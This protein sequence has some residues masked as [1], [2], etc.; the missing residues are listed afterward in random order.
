MMCMYHDG[1]RTKKNRHQQNRMQRSL[2]A[3][4][5]LILMVMTMQCNSDID[6]GFVV[7]A[8]RELSWVV[9]S[10]PGV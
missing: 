9:Y 2:Q 4:P 6:D 5:V 3:H 7:G 10:A 8:R 1:D